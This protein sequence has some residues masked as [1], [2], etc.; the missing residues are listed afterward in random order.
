V[1]ADDRPANLFIVGQHL[2]EILDLL[3]AQQALLLVLVGIV[4]AD[5]QEQNVLVQEV[6]IAP[7]ET[8][9][10]DAAF[11]GIGEIVIARHVEERHVQL[12][13]VGLKLLPLIRERAGVLRVPFDEVA[14]GN[15]E[16]RLEQ[17]DLLDGLREDARAMSAG[18]VADDDEVERLWRVVE[19]EVGPRIALVG[20]DL[21]IADQRLAVAGKTRS[22]PRPA[23]RANTLRKMRFIMAVRLCLGRGCP[24]TLSLGRGGST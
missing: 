6:V 9:L 18:A 17:V 22:P 21:Q 7:A 4:R 23:P 13:R 2:L 19:A 5:R 24:A 12:R 16:R 20:L 11:H 1:Q 14:D 8:F 15:D 10:P 3:L